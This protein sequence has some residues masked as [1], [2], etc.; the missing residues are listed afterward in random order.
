MRLKDKV[1]IVTGGSGGIGNAIVNKLSDCQA[2]VVSV[3]NNNCPLSQ[4]NENIL[5]V[6]ANLTRSEEWD[7]LLA[8]TLS[9]Y[10]RIDVLI[11]CAGFLEP[12]D[13]LSLQEDQLRKMININFTSVL[14]GIQKTLMI[15]KKQGFGHIINIGSLGGIVPMPYSAAYSA[16]KFAL[17]GF[18][19]SIAQELKDTA[20]E[21]SLITADSVNTKMLDREAIEQRP[22]ISF[23]HKP[24]SPQLVAREII[25]AIRKPKT[26]IIL[27][28]KKKL[29]ALLLGSFPN[30]FNFLYP[31]IEKHSAH[32]QKTYNE[33]RRVEMKVK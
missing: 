5:L 1:V 16:T 17:R 14:F 29:S 15:M 19:I 23:Y 3:Y 26:E 13:F 28:G 7:R 4:S 25:K 9:I 22:S 11:N 30:L 31:L 12:G 27:P 21:I 32:N 24:L 33:L 8:F 20:I 6:K 2:N 10:G 18:S